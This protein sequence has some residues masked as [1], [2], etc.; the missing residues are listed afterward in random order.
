MEEY[1]SELDEIGEF[2]FEDELDNGYN[3]NEDE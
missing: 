2:Y 1:Y 3:F